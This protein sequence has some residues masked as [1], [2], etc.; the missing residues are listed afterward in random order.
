MIGIYKI[1]NKI[2]GKCY[3]GQ[4]VNIKRRW[5][6]H[7]EIAFKKNHPGYSYPLYQAIRKYG[8]ENFNFEVLEE[9]K[10]EQLEE[11]EIF[12]IAKYDSYKNGYNQNIG[13]AHVARHCRFT[14]EDVDNV[15]NRLKTTTDSTKTIAK[16]FGVALSTI[17]ALNRGEYYRRESETYPIRSN[18]TTLTYE[19]KIKHSPQK[20]LKQKYKSYPKGICPKCGAPVFNKGSMCANCYNLSRR[21]VERPEPLELARMVKELGFQDTGKYFGVADNVI[22][23]WCKTYKIPSHIRAL[24]AWYN[25]QMGI[26][27]EPKPIKK[28][29]AE[30]VRPVNQIDKTTGEV[31]NTFA[32]QADALRHLDKPLNDNHISEVCR[33]IRKSA[34]GYFWQYAD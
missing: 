24:V 32:C 27:P 3:I 4:A 25:E 34:H 23:K 33:G 29:I 2:N 10:K 18:I 16:D 31:L 8:L 13:G 20:Q 19:S 15:I 12:Y 28:S 5:K 1:T 6:S 30:I 9:C 17:R 26:I 14:D 11:K 21:K 22:R 7:K